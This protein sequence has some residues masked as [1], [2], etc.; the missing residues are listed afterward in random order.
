MGETVMA[1]KDSTKEIIDNSLEL[2]RIGMSKGLELAAAMVKN[3]VDKDTNIIA[4]CLQK[5][6]FKLSK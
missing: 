1:E 4:T 5:E 6:A 3:S 2:L